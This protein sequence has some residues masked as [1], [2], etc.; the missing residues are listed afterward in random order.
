MRKKL[1]L[2]AS[3]ICFSLAIYL[4]IDEKIT[5]NNMS[6]E[7]KILQEMN[8]D[9]FSDE[10]S[11]DNIVLLDETLEGYFCVAI[12]SEE[13]LVNFGYIEN[14]KNKL[15]LEGKSFSSIPMIVYNEDPTLFSRTKILNSSEKDF[16]YGCYQHKDGLKVFVDDCEVKLYNFTLNYKDKEFN[17]DFWFVCSENEPTVVIK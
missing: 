6:F 2:V 17:M 14:K 11:V 1:K 8:F 13:E 10:N 9:S 3:I 7:E 4:T 16:Y 12:S 5:Y 15:E